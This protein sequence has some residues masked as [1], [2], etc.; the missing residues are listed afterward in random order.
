MYQHQRALLLFSGIVEVVSSPLCGRKRKERNPMPG[1]PSHPSY[2]R[3]VLSRI[4][5]QA[6]NR[7]EELLPWNH[8]SDLTGASTAM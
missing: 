8:I 4:A 5:E 6:I 2:L 7:I 3:N 1:H